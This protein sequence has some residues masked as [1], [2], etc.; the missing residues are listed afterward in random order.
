MC[1]YV[2]KNAVNKSALP[3]VSVWT[4]QHQGSRS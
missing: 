4:P 2:K 1:R 3:L